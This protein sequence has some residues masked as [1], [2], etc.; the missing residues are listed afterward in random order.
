[1][2]TWTV[3]LRQ[4]DLSLSENLVLQDV[5]E[6]TRAVRS[7]IERLAA[8]DEAARLA[9]AQLVAE[10]QRLDLGLGDSFRLLETEEN[11]VQAELESVRSRYDLARAT[12]RLR[13]ARG[14]IRAP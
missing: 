10:R 11:A 14:E 5:R 13:L 2:A 8:G 1:M 12:T 6:A 3:G 4:I 7:G 9:A